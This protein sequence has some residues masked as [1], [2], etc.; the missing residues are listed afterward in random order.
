MTD[1][2]NYKKSTYKENK[3]SLI[4]AFTNIDGRYLFATY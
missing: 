3:T 1:I 2:I 4:G